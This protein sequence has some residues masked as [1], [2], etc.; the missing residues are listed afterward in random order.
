MN[1]TKPSHP[2]LDPVD[3]NRLEAGDCESSDRRVVRLV[4]GLARC[5]T[6]FDVAVGSLIDPFVLLRPVREKG[7]I[8]DFVYEYANDAC[9]R[10]S[11]VA[12][13]ELIGTRILAGLA[14]L[15][16]VGMFDAYV[17]VMETGNPLE[18]D[19]FAQPSRGRGDPE[20]RRFDLR[21]LRAGELLMVRWRDVTER[22]R[23]DAE[24]TRLATIVRSSDDAIMSLDA[25]MRISTWNNA[26]EDIYGYSSQEML[27][28]WARP[29]MS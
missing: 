4:A 23:V 25:E 2:Q 15:D 19:D 11:K 17:T 24:H 5:E 13:D 8:V 12:P 14:Q 6:C 3:S 18:L 21:A 28:C 9:A 20:Q 7:E 16:P 22:D 29:A 26:A 1:V 27:R 10:A